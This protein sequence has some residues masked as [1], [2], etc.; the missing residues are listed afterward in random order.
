MPFFIF[1]LLIQTTVPFTKSNWVHQGKLNFDYYAMLGLPIEDAEQIKGNQGN[2]KKVSTFQNPA[3][4]SL[5]PCPLPRDILPASNPQ[6]VARISNETPRSIQGM[7][8]W[9]IF[10]FKKNAAGQ[11]AYWPVAIQSQW[12]PERRIVIGTMIPSIASEIEQEIEM[13]FNNTST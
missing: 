12:L 4:L 13:I 9:P 11:L 1:Q 8:G 3:L 2:L 5:E 10:G 6:F 7:S